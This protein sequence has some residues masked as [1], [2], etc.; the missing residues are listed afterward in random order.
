MRVTI[1]NMS[2]QTIGIL[3]AAP[4]TFSTGSRGFYGSGKAADNGQKFQ[5]SVNIVEIGSKPVR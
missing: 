5:I 3:E 4:R 2:G 1:Q